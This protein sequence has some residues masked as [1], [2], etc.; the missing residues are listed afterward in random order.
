MLLNRRRFNALVPT[1]LALSSSAWA[2]DK[3]LKI[4]V[5][6][7]PG[8]AADTVARAVADGMRESG[9]NAFIENRAGA[10]G[11]LAIDALMLLPADGDALVMAPSSN[12]TLSPHLLKSARQ[13][14]LS[15]LS[16]VGSAARMSFA[17][18][19]SANS[20]A[21]SLKDY[22]ALAS[23]HPAQSAYGTPG[24]GTAM[25]FIGQMLSK[26]SKVAL[27]SVSYRGGS[28]AVNDAVSGTLPAV[29]TTLPN[30]M[31]MYRS[32]RL[33]LLATSDVAQNPSTPDVPTFAAQ[34]FPRIAVTE[35]FGFF[36]RA[37]TPRQTIA[38][39]NRA[40]GAAARRDRVSALLQ[41]AEYEVR[42][43]TPE[44]LDQL[45]KSEFTRWGEIVKATGYVAE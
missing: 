27:T 4:L 39:L 1:S 35:T 8:G 29:I 20:P 34:G 44:Q 10:G 30:L 19:V 31:P 18:A 5:G 45:V 21:R 16:G 26:D 42:V 36:A 17:L 3:T 32:G 15:Q 40:I 11:R 33:R 28:A 37:G 23:A 13:D 7:A 38:D 6:Y 9:Y 2:S 25:D 12:L 22:L 24:A 14:L 41:K 43:T